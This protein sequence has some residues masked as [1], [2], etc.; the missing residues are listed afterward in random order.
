[1][2]LGT[3]IGDILVSVNPYAPLNIYGDQIGQDYGNLKLFSDMPPHIYALATKAYKSLMKS[4]VS[5]CVLVSGESGAG[6]TESTK[7]V[8]AQL[9]RISKSASSNLVEQI[10]KV[11]QL[12]EAFGNAHTVMNDNSS[13][14]G[15]LIE[16]QFLKTGVVVGGSNYPE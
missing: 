11:N 8:V 1:M 15:K 9:V 10:K 4:G 12:L 13:R 14:F 5:Q 6:K 2:D 16:I 3:Y 7:M